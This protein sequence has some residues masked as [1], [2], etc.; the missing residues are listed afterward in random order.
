MSATIL[1]NRM[2]GE[3]VRVTAADYN[4][5]TF[6]SNPFSD[7]TDWL[8]NALMTER[9]TVYPDDRD[10]ACWKV[11][12]PKGEIIAEPDDLILHQPGVGL[13]VYTRKTGV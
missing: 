1:D 13:T 9:I 11:L 6:D 8:Q 5:S 12:T 10:Y 3:A 2:D 7:G 4:G